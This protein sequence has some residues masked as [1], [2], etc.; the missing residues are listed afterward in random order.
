MQK[1]TTIKIK[2]G[3]KSGPVTK[4]S[5]IQKIITCDGKIR[6][7]TIRKRKNKKVIQSTQHVNTMYSMFNSQFQAKKLTL[8]ATQ[9]AKGSL[10]ISRCLAKRS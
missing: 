5:S 8:D 6:G 10:I 7:A 9:D 4:A 3:G 2:Q 1:V